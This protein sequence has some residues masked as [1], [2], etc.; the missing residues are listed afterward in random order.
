M[1]ETAT[2]PLTGKALLQK[3]KELSH[4]PREKQQNAAA[5]TR[6]TK[7]DQTRVNLTDFYDAVLAAKGVPS[8]QREQKMVVVGSRPIV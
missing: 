5:I 4:L 8:I 7:N 2:A 1:T 3:V 6:T